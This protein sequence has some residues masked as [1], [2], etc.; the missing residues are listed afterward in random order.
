MINN[1][2]VMKIPILYKILEYTTLNP[3]IRLHRLIQTIR[4]WE[5]NGKSKRSRAN[6]REVMPIASTPGVFVATGVYVE[7]RVVRRGML[8][9]VARNDVTKRA[10]CQASITRQEGETTPDRSGRVQ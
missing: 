7:S 1:K 5:M 9:R 4:S 6:V 10:F 3:L 8:D 2:L